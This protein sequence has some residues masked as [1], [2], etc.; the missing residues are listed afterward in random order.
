[1][2]GDWQR[3]RV[4]VVECAEVGSL[5]ADMAAVA[6]FCS[7]TP[8]YSVVAATDFDTFIVDRFTGE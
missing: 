7:S 3:Q 4:A 2:A 5:V 6:S 8:V 1:M